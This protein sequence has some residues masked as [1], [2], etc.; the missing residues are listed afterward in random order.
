MVDRQKHIHAYVTATDMLT[1]S[2]LIRH[3]RLFLLLVCLVIDRDNET[4]SNVF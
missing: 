2:K 1:S 3:S 4:L